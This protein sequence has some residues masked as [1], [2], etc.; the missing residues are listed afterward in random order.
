MGRVNTDAKNGATTRAQ[1]GTFLHH[2]I[3][4]GF[5]AVSYLQILELHVLGCV[6]WVWWQW[7][8]P[9]AAGTDAPIFCRLGQLLCLS[10]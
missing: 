1:R 5:Q 9:P 8:A 3:Q 7:N 6:L 4:N 2:E 10:L